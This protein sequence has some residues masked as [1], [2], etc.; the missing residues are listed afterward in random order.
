MSRTATVRLV[1]IEASQ[2]TAAAERWTSST[3][4]AHLRFVN[5]EATRKNQHAFSEGCPARDECRSRYFEVVLQNNEA[6]PIAPPKTEK[7][8]VLRNTLTLIA[9]TPLRHEV[10]S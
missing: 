5:H 2:I 10:G 7:S 3:G 6:K 9:I 4:G 8:Q 1:S